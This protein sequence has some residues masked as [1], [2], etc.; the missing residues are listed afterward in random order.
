MER[1]KEATENPSRKTVKVSETAFSAS[2]KP[3]LY[4]LS[5]ALPGSPTISRSVCPN[6]SAAALIDLME[7]SI[8]SLG[9]PQWLKTSAYFPAESVGE[10]DE[11]KVCT[12]FVSL[13]NTK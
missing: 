2:Q 1:K 7:P 6:L 5:A 13:S 8:P 3:S 12:N 9:R 11:F 10:F 4:K